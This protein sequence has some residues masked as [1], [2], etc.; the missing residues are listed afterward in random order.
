MALDKGDKIKSYLFGPGA[1]L[2]G[3][4]VF[5]FLVFFILRSI[6]LILSPWR[7]YWLRPAS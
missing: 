3:S 5:W 2:V 1:M 6:F 4:V 7:V